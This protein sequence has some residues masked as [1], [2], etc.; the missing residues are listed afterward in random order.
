MTA[1]LLVAAGGALG[2]GARY[3]LVAAIP[4]RF[5][6]SILIANVAGSFALGVLL[7]WADSEAMLLGG[8]GF[9]GALTT[10]STFALD[11]HLLAREGRRLAS[12]VN[13]AVSLA[14]SILALMAG[15]ALAHTLGL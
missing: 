5:P 9:C 2:A 7:V 6:W 4:G 13:I 14:G 10:F 3:L 15:L 11:T 8:I 12:V 1:F